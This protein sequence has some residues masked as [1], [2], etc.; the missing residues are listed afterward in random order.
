M[1]GTKDATSK[2]QLWLQK[3]SGGFS[4]FVSR[5]FPQWVTNIAF[6]VLIAITIVNSIP[7]VELQLLNVVPYAQYYV[8]VFFLFAILVNIQQ[9]NL[10]LIRKSD[11]TEVLNKITSEKEIIVNKIFSDGFT[12]AMNIAKNASNQ[13]QTLTIF[14]Q[15]GKSYSQAIAQAKIQINEIK[16]LIVDPCILEEKNRE[17]EKL[18]KN[19]K[20]HFFS[21]STWIDN[22]SDFVGGKLENYMRT[23]SFVPGFHFAII[24]GRY[25]FW[26]KLKNLEE[27]DSNQVRVGEVYTIDA[28][29][30][31]GQVF[32]DI[33]NKFFDT[34]YQVENK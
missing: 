15:G 32:L 13:V 4:S 34:Y 19:E 5:L 18:N 14:A 27:T 23:Y 33:I 29:N 9:H 8:I 6:I 28:G 10:N 30:P 7:G 12:D 25:L 31:S 24:N 3:I 21:H 20:Y 16:L 1:N 22:T 17:R 11:M 26:G 2:R